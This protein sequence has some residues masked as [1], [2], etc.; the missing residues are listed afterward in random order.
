MFKV[1]GFVLKSYPFGESHKIINVLTKESGK[2]KIIARGVKKT[3]S[4]YGSS[5]ELLNEVSLLLV[6]AK[7]ND[8]YDIRESSINTSYHHLREDLTSIKLIYYLVEFL[9]QMTQ[10][11]HHDVRVY[12]LLKNVLDRSLEN[13]TPLYELTKSFILKTLQMSGFLSDINECSHCSQKLQNQSNDSRKK[14][15]ISTRSGWI[16]CRN[17]H[18][19]SIDQEISPGTYR[20]VVNLLNLEVDQVVRLKMNKFFKLETDNAID[21]LITSILGRKLKVIEWQ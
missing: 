14:I 21:K 13:I 3:S 10:E 2:M 4:K 12:D 7:G 20:F 15:Y 8:L 1:T 16:F 19:Q 6:P 17:C 9:D 18:N 5:F 11:D